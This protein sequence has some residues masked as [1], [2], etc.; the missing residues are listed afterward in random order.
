MCVSRSAQAQ[1]GR[2]LPPRSRRIQVLLQPVGK[3]SQVTQDR[4][5][6]QHALELRPVDP[7]ILV[8]LDNIIRGEGQP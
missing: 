4:E 2:S 8:E 5:P 3:T 6:Y 7:D 1:N